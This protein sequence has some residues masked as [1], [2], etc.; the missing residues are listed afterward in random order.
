MK[1]NISWK[2]SLLIALICYGIK[3][4]FGSYLGTYIL[5]ILEI[6]GL[7]TLILGIIG[8]LRAAFRKK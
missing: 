6:A 2:G 7:I 3:F 8:G 5:A 4:L 1:K